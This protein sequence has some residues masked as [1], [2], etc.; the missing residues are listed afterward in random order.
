MIKAIVKACTPNRLMASYILPSLLLVNFISFTA[1]ATTLR[2][3]DN[4]VLRDVDDKPIEQGFLLKKQSIRLSSGKHTLVLK[5]KDVFEDFDFGDERLVKSD[6]FVVKFLLGAQQ[7]LYLST[8]KITDLA[9]AEK[10]ARKPELILMDEDNKE[11]ELVLE[12]LVDYE[13]SKH[14]TQ[15][16]TTLSVPADQTLINTQA[17]EK[18]TKD[19]RFSDNVIKQVDAMPMLK[20]WWEKAT[21][22]EKINFRNF[23]NKSS[24]YNNNASG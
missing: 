5:Y 18:G 12:K 3:S 21:P 17:I 9:S 2:I 8:S 20:Y 10:F 7:E 24:K 1:G 11:L 6:Y 19:R 13:L 22:E 15:V 4:L 23:I 14:V 16:V